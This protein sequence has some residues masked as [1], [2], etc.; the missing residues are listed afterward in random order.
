MHVDELVEA[1]QQRHPGKETHLRAGRIVEFSPSH[2]PMPCNPDDDYSF[3]TGA[4]SPTYSTS[5]Y[6]VNN[7]V[8]DVNG[9][10]LALEY[11]A[12]L[13]AQQWLHMAR[14]D[15]SSDDTTMEESG[16]RVGRGSGGPSQ[17]TSPHNKDPDMVSD[18]EEVLRG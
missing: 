8:D 2:P 15:S 4:T 12:V 14:G 16:A 17:G 3:S 10:L 7:N 18:R 13:D 11:Q 1:F 9:S 5:N 6:D